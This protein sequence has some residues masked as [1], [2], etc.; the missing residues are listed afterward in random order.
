MHKHLILSA[1]LLAILAACAR[2]PGQEPPAVPETLSN[3]PVVIR[4]KTGLIVIDASGGNSVFPTQPVPL[5]FDSKVTAAKW[6]AEH[7]NA[8]LIY[9]NNRNVVGARGL[10]IQFGE[11]FEADGETESL[12]LVEDPIAHILGGPDGYI[13]FKGRKSC[14]NPAK[15]DVGQKGRL[16]SLLANA[17]LDSILDVQI[18]SHASASSTACNSANTYCIKGKSWDTNWWV[19]H[20]IGSK[21]SQDKGGYR[22][23]RHFCWKWGFI[24]WVCSKKE[25]SNHL[26]VTAKYFGEPFGR[27]NTVFVMDRFRQCDNCQSVKARLWS[28]FVSIG[29]SGAPGTLC[30]V[31]CELTGVCGIHFGRG[32]EGNARTN[33]AKNDH[34]DAICRR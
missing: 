26:E 27:P 6:A 29:S 34:I 3:E 30:T 12:T 31:E 5:Q 15:C 32:P 9:D 25:G 19:Y 17:D 16:S 14:V 7:L 11:L 13:V 33:T 4:E 24:P 10:V 23:T 2:G 21:T 1:A 28:I 18:A 20:S 22:V 8:E